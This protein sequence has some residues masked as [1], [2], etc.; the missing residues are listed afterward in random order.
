MKGQPMR[1]NRP[2]PTRLF[3]AVLALGLPVAALAQSIAGVVPPPT[4]PGSVS[5]AAPY[6][7]PARPGVMAQAAARQAILSKE[8]PAA[9]AAPAVAA[10]AAATQQKVMAADAVAAVTPTAPAG[11]SRA[12]GVPSA[13]PAT[14]SGSLLDIALPAKPTPDAAPDLKPSA[15]KD[16]TSEP[17]HKAAKHKR[18][19]KQGVPKEPPAIDPFAGVDVTSVSDSQLNRFVFPEPVEGVYFAEGA[20]LPECAANAGPQ[21]PCKPVFLNGRRM[22]LL[23]LRAGAK[24]PVQMLVH[25]YSGR[26]VTLNLLPAAGV[27]AVVRVDNA[28]DGAS[29]ARMTSERRAGVTAASASNAGM[30]DSEQNVQLLTRFAKGDMPAGFEPEQVGAPVRYELFD[31]IPMAQWSDGGNWRVHLMQVK[32]FSDQPVAINAGLFRNER[33]RAIAL[34]RDTITNSQPAQLY[35]LEYVPTEQQ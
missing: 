26:V 34:D 33:V 20:P 10:P 19:S 35:L 9:A 15:P 4:P 5:Q 11:A 6:V 8:T 7:L 28:E 13:Q 25:L 30:S 3:L 31:V 14:A 18:A 17:A 27:G 12:A 1:V 32:A 21:D 2:R 22:M 16:A 23:Q 29:D 24:G